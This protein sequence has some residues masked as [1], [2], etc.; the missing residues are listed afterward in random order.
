MISKE[1][2]KNLLKGEAGSTVEVSYLRQKKTYTAS[3]R[4]E[5]IE[6][7]AVPYFAMTNDSIGYIALVKFNRKAS[8]ET[9]KALV[10]LKKQGAKK[11]ILDLRNNPGGLLSEAI[12][13]TNLF[14]PKNQLVVTTKSKVKKYNK[15]YLTKNEPIDTEI[16]LA[17]IIN[18]RSA[19]ASEIVSGSLQDLD[20]AVIIGNRSYGKGL[21]QRPK[22]LSYGTQM[23]ITISRYYTPSGRCIQALDYSKKDD[24]GNALKI[25]KS[26]YNAF[27]T[28]KGRTVY[29]GGGIDPDLKVEFIQNQNLI[30]AIKKERLVFD[31]ATK[32]Y[33]ENQ[34]K[35]I[36]DLTFNDKLFKEFNLFVKDKGFNFE[37]KTERLL[38]QLNTT[39]FE[40]GVSMYLDQDLKNIKKHIKNFKGLCYRSR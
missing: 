15:T 22:K 10:D 8:Y 19:S 33:Y 32:Y 14:I 36:N 4:R 39:A 13:I 11:I 29:D 3:I 7:K 17:I 28:K 31:F 35:N 34:N 30:K 2:S 23:K 12:N 38:D 40:E 21:V 1:D 26:Q 6:I 5:A 27:K 20:R 25:D 24:N 16:P 18:D 9:K 37:T